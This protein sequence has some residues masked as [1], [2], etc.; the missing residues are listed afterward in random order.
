MATQT[1]MFLFADIGGCTAMSQ[2]LGDASYVGAL[3]GHHR[4]LRAGLA[5][6]GGE[7]VVTGGGDCSAV[8]ALLRACAD[9]AIGVR[10]AL[11]WHAR[12]AGERVRARMGIDGGAACWM[13]AGRAARIAAVARAGQVLVPAAAAGLL[14]GSLPAEVR[15]TDLGLHQPGDGGRAER[16]FQV[17][18]GGL[19][20]AFAPLRS[21]EGARQ[22]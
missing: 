14:A 11:A 2:R 9:A 12:P 3:A 6:Q 21:V 20:A 15:L 1:R 4:L 7:E 17:E 18:A 16:I 8:C 10:R 22:C 5:A 13:A 19:P